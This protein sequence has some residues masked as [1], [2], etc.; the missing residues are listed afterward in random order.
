VGDLV[1]RLGAN[2]SAYAFLVE[3][4]FLKGREKLPGREVLSL[5]RN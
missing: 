5:I 4:T 3:L 2:V 1:D